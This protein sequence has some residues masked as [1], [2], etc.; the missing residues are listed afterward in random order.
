[1]EAGA[2]TSDALNAVLTPN[3]PCIVNDCAA[4]ILDFTFDVNCFNFE[5]EGF[6]F[7]CLDVDCF[8]GEEDDESVESDI[9]WVA[10][11]ILRWRCG[12]NCVVWDLVR[13]KPTSGTR[14]SQACIQASV[15]P[16]VD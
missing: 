16:I 14:M 8:V 1:M 6:G 11:L 15:S 2:S 5:A 12:D 9:W 13:S 3:E 7:A 10:A 4:P